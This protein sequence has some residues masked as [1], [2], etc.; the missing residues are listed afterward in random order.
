MVEQHRL[1][2]RL[3]EVDEVVVPADVRELVRQHRLDLLRG[4]AAHRCSREQQHRLQRPDDYRHLDPRGLE[5]LYGCAQPEPGRQS[6]DGTDPRL[7]RL[8]RILTN[9]P[10]CLPPP[11]RESNRAEAD[12]DKPARNEPREPDGG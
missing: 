12:A 10:A 5:Q 9:E 11:A 2:N 3:N 8:E 6:V 7:V 1:H 4:E